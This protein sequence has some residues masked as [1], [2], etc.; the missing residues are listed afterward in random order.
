VKNSLKELEALLLLPSPPPN[1]QRQEEEE[2]KEQEKQNIATGVALVSQTKSDAKLVLQVGEMVGYVLLGTTGFFWL[3]WFNSPYF[4]Y[5]E[6]PV[7]AGIILIASSFI[8][9]SK[10]NKKKFVEI[11]KQ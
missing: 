1:R 9:N 7:I 4:E 8:Y 11:K 3:F 6:I 2:K 10:L 5:I